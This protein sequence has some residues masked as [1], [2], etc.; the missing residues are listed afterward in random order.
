VGFVAWGET[1]CGVEW[2]GPEWTGQWLYVQ[3]RGFLPLE[4][5]GKPV[6]VMERAFEVALERGGHGLRYRPT[7]SNHEENGNELVPPGSVVVGFQ[8]CGGEFVWVRDH[9]YLPLSTSGRQVLLPLLDPTGNSPSFHN[10]I[11]AWTLF[12]DQERHWGAVRDRL[13]NLTNGE[14]THASSTVHR[15]PAPPWFFSMEYLHMT[16]ITEKFARHWHIVLSGA[17]LLQ[18]GPRSRYRVSVK[19]HLRSFGPSSF[20]PEKC[21]GI[22]PLAWLQRAAWQ[23]YT[24]V[25]G[26]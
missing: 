24:S 5:G 22:S 4:R 10:G 2:Y 13:D 26:D 12:D 15:F 8:C 3:G 25:V 6:L 7:I 16:G 1:V 14:I 18:D 11:L 20:S 17:N 9:G 21:P 23:G 19:S